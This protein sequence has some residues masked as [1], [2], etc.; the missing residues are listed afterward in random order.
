MS[1]AVTAKVY[2][3]NKT[4]YP[5]DGTGQ[6]QF[7]FYPDYANGTNKAWASA[8]PSLNFQITVADG[9]LFTVGSKYTVTFDLDEPAEASEA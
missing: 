4:A 2:C 9:E 1:R 5:P 3:G 6:A 8:T 7:T